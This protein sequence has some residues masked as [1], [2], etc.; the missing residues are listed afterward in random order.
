MQLRTNDLL[1]HH[2]ADCKNVV[3][4]LQQTSQTIHK[5]SLER[6]QKLHETFQQLRTLRY[7]CMWKAPLFRAHDRAIPIHVVTSQA[8]RQ[9]C[10]HA[11]LHRV[12]Q[13][14]G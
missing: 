13:I 1:L 3:G 14:Y 4:V 9:K 6:L 7:D 12:E 5:R 11:Q 10:S 2:H 8:H